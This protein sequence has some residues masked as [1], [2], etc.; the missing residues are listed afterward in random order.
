M[1]IVYGDQ[2][3]VNCLGKPYESQCENGVHR[4][5]TSPLDKSMYLK[6]IFLISKEQSQ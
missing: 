4:A 2:Q 5:Y 6:L 1:Y 3:G